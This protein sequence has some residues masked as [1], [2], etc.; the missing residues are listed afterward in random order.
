MKDDPPPPPPPEPKAPFDAFKDLTRRLLAVP[1][2]EI[3]RREVA[4]Q[5][6]QA[7]KPKRGPKPKS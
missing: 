5:R 2:A 1:K 7:K 3:E 4:Y 6:K